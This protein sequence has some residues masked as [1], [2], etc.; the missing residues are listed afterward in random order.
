MSGVLAIEASQRAISVAIRGRDGRVHECA[1]SGDTR[2]R[3]LLLPAIIEL[4]EAAAVHRRDLKAI[5]VST[6]PGGFTGLRVAIS[7]AK[8]LCEGLCVPAVDVA[9]A[10]VAAEGA[11]QLWWTGSANE[12]VVVALASKGES[13]WLST[14]TS[15]GPGSLTLANE[16]ISSTATFD[17]PLSGVLLADEHLP[18]PLRARALER[19][20]RI[21]PPTFRA[22]HCLTVSEALFAQGRAIDPIALR[23]RYPREPDAVT[24]WRDRYPDGFVAK[25]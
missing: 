3:D 21:E 12:S 8:G 9:S 24:L 14:I 22:A 7:T 6:G 19:G 17:G 2:D 25:K 11:R 20:M 5:A 18:A 13:C 1:P 16:G 4:C 10:L 15:S 23:V